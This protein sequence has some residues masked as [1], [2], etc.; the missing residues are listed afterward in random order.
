MSLYASRTTAR[1]S[2]T[3]THAV[4]P[5]VLG[6]GDSGCRVAS[7][8]VADDNYGRTIAGADILHM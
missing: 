2:A 5:R 6:V 8:G 7:V 1:S 4:F 3:H